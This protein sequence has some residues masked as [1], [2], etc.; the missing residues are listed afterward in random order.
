MTVRDMRASF[1]CRSYA[2]GTTRLDDRQA[3]PGVKVN[4]SP[5]LPLLSLSEKS[6]KGA[7]NEKNK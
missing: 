7:R 1:F 3:N 4:P 5:A 2:P 6:K